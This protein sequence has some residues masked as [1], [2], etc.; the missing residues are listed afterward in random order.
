MPASRLAPGA[1]ELFRAWRAELEGWL[2]CPDAAQRPVFAAHMSKY[3]STVPAL[4]LLFHLVDVVSG[5]V[6]AGAVSLKAMQLGEAWAEF[7]FRHALRVYAEPLGAAG[8]SAH[9]L[10]TRIESGAVR[11]EM[12]LR[13]LAQHRWSG[14]QS[15]DD[16]DAAVSALERSHWVRRERRE[17]GGRP[18]A[19]IRL[20]PKLRGVAA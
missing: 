2:C 8:A 5:R 14:L 19:V 4:A 9:A 11:D 10:A 20:H 3:K 1:L 12:T 13:D 6:E 18:S 15:A 16:V 17:T 7:L